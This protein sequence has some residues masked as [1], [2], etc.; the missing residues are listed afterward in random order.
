M[1]PWDG[2]G[3]YYGDQ[4]HRGGIF[5]NEFPE[6]WYPRQIVAEQHGNSAGREDILLQDSATGSEG[7]SEGTTCSTRLEPVRAV[8]DHSWDGRFYRS[9]EGFI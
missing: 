8:L 4:A 6:V 2:A 9:C 1:T 3:D 7:S 5:S